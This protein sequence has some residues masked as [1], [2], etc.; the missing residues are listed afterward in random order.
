MSI[1]LSDAELGRVL[2]KG[3]LYDEL[4]SSYGQSVSLIEG[5]ALGDSAG[6]YVLC[7]LKGQ[8]VGA[9]QAMDLPTVVSVK[10]GQTVIVSLS[11][12]NLLVIGVIGEGDSQNEAIDKAQGS[13]DD[14]KKS[15]DAAFSASDLAKQAAEDAKKEAEAAKSASESAVQ[16]G[17]DITAKVEASQQKI[18]EAVGKVDSISGTVEANKQ[19]IE[20]NNAAIE[21]NKKQLAAADQKIADAVKKVDDIQPTLDDAAKQAQAAKD[22]AAQAQKSA[23]DA[24]KNVDAAQQKADQALKDAAAAGDKAA[25]AAGK[26]EVLIQSEEPDPKYRTGEVLWIDTTDG[27]NTPK[28]WAARPAFTVADLAKL[29]VGEVGRTYTVAELQAS[30]SGSAWVPVTDQSIIDAADQAALAR[31]TA[32]GKNKV[33]YD[34]YEPRYAKM[35]QGDLWM[36]LNPLDPQ[37]TI[38]VQIWNGAKWVPYKLVIDELAVPSSIGTVSIHDGAITSP[39]VLAGA[40]EAKHIAVGAVEADKIAA[41]AVQ[42]DKIAAGAIA[43]DKLAAG[44]VTGD[45]VAANTITAK[46][47]TLTNFSNL[48]D[49]PGFAN[50]ITGAKSSWS[51]FNAGN[52]T[53]GFALGTT[54]EGR[55]FAY[56]TGSNIALRN[57]A[58]IDVEPGESYMVKADCLN[59]TGKTYVKLS[60]A[61]LNDKGQ[62]SWH[63]GIARTKKAGE[64]ERVGGRFTIPDGAAKMYFYACVRGA[65][66]GKRTAFANAAVTRMADAELIVD[67]SI[68]ARKIKADSINAGHLQADSVGTEQLVANSINSDKLAANSVVTEKI[69]AGAVTASKLTLTDLSNCIINGS[70]EDGLEKWGRWG[71]N[72][73]TAFPEGRSGGKC[74]SFN[75]N[76]SQQFGITSEWVSVAP[77]QAFNAAGY[78]RVGNNGVTVPNSTLKIEYLNSKN[79]S[80]PIGSVPIPGN[81]W[82]WTRHSVGAVVPDGVTK[83]RVSIVIPNVKENIQIDDVQLLRMA[84]AELIVDGSIT[85]RKIAA[86]AITAEKADITG[87]GAAFVKGGVLRA[88]DSKTGA[89]VVMTASGIMG[90][91]SSGKATFALEAAT[92]NLKT[93]GSVGG[94]DLTELTK[95]TVIDW[96]LEY[97]VG[98]SATT[99]PDTASG[100]SSDRPAVPNGKYLWS[101]EYTQTADGTVKRSQPSRVTGDKGAKGDKGDRGEKGEKGEKGATGDRGPQG[102]TGVNGTPGKGVKSF[103]VTYQASGS[104]TTAPT[105][106]WSAN[107]PS[108]GA[109]QYLWTRIVYTYTDNTT[110]TAYA[111]ARNGSNG[112]QGPAGKN[113]TNGT[114]GSNGKN[115]QMLVGLCST[116]S[117]VRDK[118][119]WVDGYEQYAGATV[120]IKFTYRNTAA[121]CRLNVNGKGWGDLIARGEQVGKGVSWMPNVAVICVFDGKNWLVDSG[122]VVDTAIKPTSDGLYLWR[123]NSAGT[124]NNSYMLLT[125]SELQIYTGNAKSSSYAAGRIDLGLDRSDTDI[126]MSRGSFHLYSMSGMGFFSSKGNLTLYPGGEDADAAGAICR[127]AN[128]DNGINYDDYK[129]VGAR[130]LW[131]GD[132][133]TVG[134]VAYRSGMLASATFYEIVFS[135]GSRLYSERVWPTDG[136]AT[137]TSCSRSVVGADGVLYVSSMVVTRQTNGGWRIDRVGDAN[138]KNNGSGQLVAPNTSILHLKKIIAWN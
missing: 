62:V 132:L 125:G 35:A 85:G 7:D 49:D 133:S 129:V 46:S 122:A 33:T 126:Y 89:E 27:R 101:R 63:E 44:S 18:D 76:V 53:G 29:T 10:K 123:Q 127:V 16:Q 116:A 24:I 66:D 6:G 108:T 82:V 107:V 25:A 73:E 86:G 112:A 8:V 54:A 113:G 58:N 118:G 74:V 137:S 96:H 103:S 61:T 50:G 28:Q 78:F 47:L 69:A 134:Q 34:I 87:L 70:F 40:I 130:L 67:G 99:A 109:G 91:N 135:D 136:V 20:K 72:P 30:A 1:E 119:A 121:S 39:K 95:L 59:D 93:S 14:A 41:G 114:N 124:A 57:T 100:W 102:P 21:D 5:L 26:R 92:G 105:G 56:T 81:G 106:T 36:Q 52:G 60:L 55:R 80:V 117:D 38:G 12:G 120:A 15:A 13:A 83:I 97:K 138:L 4:K 31:Q 84:N 94:G 104:G 98:S 17:K 42:A 90:Y 131:S 48:I 115:G 3:D 65:A 19:A 88:V 2:V 64:W 45:K 79:E 111:V 51:Y 75:R 128:R 71:A 23:D 22:A 110:S 68:D 77:G 11:G 37:Q 9:D 43:S 32:D